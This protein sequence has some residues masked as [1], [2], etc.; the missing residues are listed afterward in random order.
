MDVC[1]LTQVG[2]GGAAIQLAVVAVANLEFTISLVL[3][4][5]IFLLVGLFSTKFIGVDRTI[6]R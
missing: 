6:S 2:K 3:H 1:F 5:C 4:G